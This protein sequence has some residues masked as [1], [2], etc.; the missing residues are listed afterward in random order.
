MPEEPRR[1]RRPPPP[2]IEPPLK[3]EVVDEE[4]STPF[5]WRRW[6][7]GGIAFAL[8]GTAGYYLAQRAAGY[9]DLD[10]LQEDVH[11]L[12]DRYAAVDRDYTESM[13]AHMAKSPFGQRFGPDAAINPGIRGATREWVTAGI[14]LVDEF[15]ARRERLQNDL[16][17]RISASRAPETSKDAMLKSTRDVALKLPQPV[18][19]MMGERAYLEKIGE[20]AAYLDQNA[21]GIALEEGQLQFDDGAAGERYNVLLRELAAAERERD[22]LK[23]Q[24]MRAGEL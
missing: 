1:R 23:R 19:I 24:V 9:R 7:L 5:P 4:A 15:L 13:A 12:R 3:M 17:A 11:H 6:I 22:R 8:I 2:P 14:A 18:R 10:V 16:V 20:V 21:Q